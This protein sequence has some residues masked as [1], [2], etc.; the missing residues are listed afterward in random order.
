MRHII[1]RE[2]CLG[3]IPTGAPGIV[4]PRQPLALR[5][6]ESRRQEK[7]G[8]QGN[9]NNSGEPAK[10]PRIRFDLTHDFPPFCI[11]NVAPKRGRTPLKLSPHY[12]NPV[13]Q[14]TGVCDAGRVSQ[15]CLI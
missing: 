9:A 12:A 11:N 8:A 4:A 6:G 1:L 15:S 14:I 2:R 7:R 5:G 13:A 10:R 3:I